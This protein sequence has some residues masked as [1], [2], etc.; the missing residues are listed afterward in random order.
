M[1][2]YID[3]QG[4]L[5]KPDGVG[6]YTGSVVRELISIDKDNAYR[7]LAFA[8]QRYRPRLVPAAELKYEFLPFP[9]QLYNQT[10]KRIKPWP[11]NRFLQRKP[12][13]VIYPNFINFPR[14]K[15][16]LSIIVIHDL[17]FIDVPETLAK[18]NLSYLERFVPKAL[19]EASAVVAVSEETRDAI[20][21]RFG[22]NTTSITVVPN[23]VNDSFFDD[24]SDEVK[25][26]VR[27]RYGLP[28]E[29]ILFLGTI[30]PRKNL[31]RLLEAYEKLPAKLYH[32]YPLVLA[33]KP[34]WNSDG[35]YK[36]IHELL[37]RGYSI[38]PIGF[39][40]DEDLPAIFNMAEIFVYPSIAEG[41]GLQ[42]LESMAAGTP[43][44]TS[45]KPPMNRLAKG[46]GEFI[47]PEQPG[48]ITTAMKKLL[49]NTRTRN[50]RARQSKELARKH[51]WHRSAHIMHDL[52]KELQEK[53]DL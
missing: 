52:I 15:D 8:D 27:E 41:F 34:G 43:V 10:Y 23:A 18:K 26:R 3:A 24:I 47:N 31:E 5:R 20:A 25:Q 39:T 46:V 17:A 38:L 35:I 50:A 9:Y 19:H 32:Q 7:A 12:N 42:I 2:I 33:G 29:F 13:L 48:S 37:E 30:E 1:N 36:K 49:G 40:E 6:R 14:I 4:L 11:V 16:A 21:K 45:D 28:D 22:I 53:H 51:T 44:V